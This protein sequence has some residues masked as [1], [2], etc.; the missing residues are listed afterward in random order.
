MDLPHTL[1]PTD[2]V[3]I[4]APMVPPDALRLTGPWTV[5]HHAG[6]QRHADPGRASGRRGRH[7]RRASDPRDPLHHARLVVLPLRMPFPVLHAV[8]RAVERE[9]L[10]ARADRLQVR[11]HCL[12]L[13]P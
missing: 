11:R 8:R 12:P 10:V 2:R 3:L 7:C 1:Y 13:C 5:T 9:Q 4:E 6:R